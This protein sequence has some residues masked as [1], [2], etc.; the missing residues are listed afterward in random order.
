MNMLL[1]FTGFDYWLFKK[2]NGEWHSTFFDQF[3]LTLRESVLWLPLYFF[4]I[5]FVAINFKKNGFIWILLF[6]V[7]AMFSDIISSSVIK[8]L[9]PRLRPC[10]D[11]NL[12]DSIRFLAKYCP[13]S[14]SFTSS[15]AVNHFSAAMFIF[16]TFKKIIS[17]WLWLLFVWAALI[18]YAQVYVGVHFP[19]DV[20][21]GAI[22]GLIIGYFP[23]LFFNRRVGFYPVEIK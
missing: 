13:V 5:V 6:M 16:T 17:N 11:V 23:A 15:H 21:G 7:M 22:V 19:L 4:L 12:A 3:F 18:C 1:S 2:I 8:E 10:R 14:S 20:I 9:V